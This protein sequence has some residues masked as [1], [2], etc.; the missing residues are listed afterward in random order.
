V[1]EYSFIDSKF[2]LVILA[3]RRAK[4]L[5]RGSKKKVD[6]NA[7]NPLTVALKEIE[8]GLVNFEILNEEIEMEEVVE[9][10][11]ESDDEA[12]DRDDI[13]AALEKD[14]EDEDEEVEEDEEDE[15]F[16]LSSEDESEDELVE[17]EEEVS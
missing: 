9:A 7:E 16:E 11:G 13:F 1:E 8:S 6:I 12:A 17:P 2:R 5:V 10:V 3:A 14:E 4:Q 15:D